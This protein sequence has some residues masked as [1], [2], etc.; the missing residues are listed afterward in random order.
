VCVCLK[1]KSESL[2]DDAVF[3]NNRNVDHGKFLLMLARA[4][5][6]MTKFKQL[7]SSYS[8]R[9]GPVPCWTSEVEGSI[10]RQLF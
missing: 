8:S 1:E 6:G 4:G 2:N 3:R 7:S 5:G 9:L 10:S